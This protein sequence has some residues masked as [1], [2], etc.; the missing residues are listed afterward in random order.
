MKYVLSE[1]EREE[2]E[3]LR[4]LIRGTP[5]KRREQQDFL[6]AIESEKAERTGED[7]KKK[8]E[9]GKI[10]FLEREQGQRNGEVFYFKRVYRVNGL[11]YDIDN[12][13]NLP[14]A[15]EKYAFL[16]KQKGSEK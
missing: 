10:G 13:F 9:R 2:I 3:Y 16:E 14:P 15:R 5:A 11:V 8:L 12:L 6:D 1:N 4:M 7:M